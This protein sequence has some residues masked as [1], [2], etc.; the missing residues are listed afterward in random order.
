MAR[1]LVCLQ[2]MLTVGC[3]PGD[4][5]LPGHVLMAAPEAGLSLTWVP[6]ITIPREAESCN[7]F[8]NAVKS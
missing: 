3:V 6:R 2:L 1:L 7:A 8:S 5:C 4:V